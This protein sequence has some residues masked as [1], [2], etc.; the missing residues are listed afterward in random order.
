MCK[1]HVTFVFLVCKSGVR[2]RQYT[3][4][5]EMPLE[6]A[7]PHFSCDALLMATGSKALE[8]SIINKLSPGDVD[9]PCDNSTVSVNR[10]QLQSSDHTHEAYL[11]GMSPQWTTA[12][13]MSSSWSNSNTVLVFRHTKTTLYFAFL[14]FKTETFCVQA[15]IRFYMQKT[16]YGNQTYQCTI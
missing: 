11:Q 16:L 13:P 8:W 6:N 15:H 5:T 14:H 4:D 9:M 1:H 2:V 12:G 10:D 3:T 7:T